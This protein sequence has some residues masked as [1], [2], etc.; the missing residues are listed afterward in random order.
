MLEEEKH[1]LE[2]TIEEVR[3]QKEQLEFLLEAHKPICGS[4]KLVSTSTV[5]LSKNSVITAAVITAAKQNPTSQ[6]ARSLL[7]NSSV[8]S[9]GS[10]SLRPNTLVL[11]KRPPEGLVDAGLLSTPSADFYQTMGLDIMLEGHTGLTPITANAT[12]INAGLLSCT[13][14]QYQR[15]SS[16]SS[17]ESNSALMAL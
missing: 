17:G 2:K 8:S 6:N 9:N 4:G 1:K 16:S 10:S 7:N 14:Q 15:T 11:P 12:P 13:N 3:L 5:V